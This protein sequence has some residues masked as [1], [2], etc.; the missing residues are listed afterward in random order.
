MNHVTKNS[1]LTFSLG[2]EH[3]LTDKKSIQYL[4]SGE[5]FV[6]SHFPLTCLIQ[7]VEPTGVRF[8]F[9][10]SKKKLKRAVDRNAVK[11]R[12]REACR[13]QKSNWYQKST[14]GLHIALIYQPSQIHSVQEME[15]AFKKCLDDY[16][17]RN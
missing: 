11:R 6:S 2:K 10:V 12:L 3:S 14:K 13:F 4:F 9:V 16:F 1:D 5:K 7:R 8:L 17:R 15:N